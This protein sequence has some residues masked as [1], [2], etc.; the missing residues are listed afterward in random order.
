MQNDD[1][2]LKFY[3]LLRRSTGFFLA[4]V[5][6]M[7]YHHYHVFI[8]IIAI[9]KHCHRDVHQCYEQCGTLFKIYSDIIPLYKKQVP[10]IPT[11]FDFDA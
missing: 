9:Q 2:I 5:Y 8:L 10:L 6:N 3:G 1:D 11:L 4:T 7:L